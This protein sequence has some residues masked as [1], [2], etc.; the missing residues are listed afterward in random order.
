VATVL[1]AVHANAAA[2]VEVS[3]LSAGASN[4]L[5]SNGSP[6]LGEANL[7]NW[8]LGGDGLN[9]NYLEFTISA[10]PNRTISITHIS[11]SQ[12]RNGLGA[13]DG[14]AFEVSINEAAFEPYGIVRIDPFSEDGV[15][16]RY[17]FTQSITRVRSVVIRFA[18][19]SV[20]I[21]STGNLHINGLTVY[22]DTAW[23]RF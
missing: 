12:W 5:Y 2:R 4:L 8:D 17:T 16:D 22:G 21:G 3:D 6:A 9:D 18:P 7:K 1:G 15:F 19:R 23:S 11:I 10:G 13:P 14:L 20:N